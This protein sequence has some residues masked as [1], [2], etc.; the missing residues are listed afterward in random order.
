[1]Y[2]YFAGGVGFY[3]KDRLELFISPVFESVYY[4]D[5]GKWFSNPN[6]HFDIGA[7]YEFLLNSKESSG[8]VLIPGISI[9]NYIDGFGYGYEYSISVCPFARVAYFFTSRFAGYVSFE[10][11]YIIRTKEPNGLDTYLNFGAEYYF[12]RFMK[13]LFK[14]KE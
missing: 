2:L 8:F 1:M 14:K 6:G 3:P 9:G 13:I 4:Q 7:K 11:R 10:P 12:P 5:K